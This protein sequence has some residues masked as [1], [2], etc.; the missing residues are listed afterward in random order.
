MDMINKAFLEVLIEGDA[1]GRGF[2]YP[3]PTYNLTRNFNWESENATLLFKMTG[4]YGTPYFQN[5]INSKLNPSDV[6]HVLQA[7]A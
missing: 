1:D 3:I 6:L 7:A 5:F 2:S 4:K